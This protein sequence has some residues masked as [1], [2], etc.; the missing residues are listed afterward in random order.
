M[1]QFRLVGVL[2]AAIAVML[3]WQGLSPRE[4]AGG[5]MIGGKNASPAVC[6]VNGALTVTCPP[7]ES[8]LICSIIILVCS[9]NGNSIN[10]CDRASNQPCPDGAN[11]ATATQELC[12][13]GTSCEPSPE[14]VP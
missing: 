11:C 8:G 6:C 2:P 12:F 3:G 14:P 1:R 7:T 4:V 5:E 10:D 13:I 9:Q